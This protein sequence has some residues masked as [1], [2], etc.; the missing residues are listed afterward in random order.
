[1]S[2][3]G[4]L[5]TSVPASLAIRSASKTEIGSATNLTLASVKSNMTY[6]TTIINCQSARSRDARPRPQPRLS[7]GVGTPEL[8]VGEQK[9]CEGDEKQSELV[10]PQVPQ[11]RVCDALLRQV[12]FTCHTDNNTHTHTHTFNSPFSGTTQVR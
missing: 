9:E 8:D 3:N 11:R 10:L 5:R 1:M 12:V 7:C 2:N 6:E 4:R